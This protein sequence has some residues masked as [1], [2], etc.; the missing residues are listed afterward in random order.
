MITS[1][2]SRTARRPRRDSSSSATAS[3]RSR[4]RRTR[5]AHVLYRNVLFGAVDLLDGSRQGFY[6]YETQGPGDPG[7]RR[8]ARHRRRAGP[9]AGLSWS[10]GGPSG[11]GRATR[12]SS[13]SAGT[14]RRWRTARPSGRR[15]R[16]SGH[17]ADPAGHGIRDREERD[18]FSEPFPHRR[19]LHRQERGRSA[20][21]PFSTRSTGIT[22]SSPSRSRRGRSNDPEMWGLWP[23][24][25]G[26]PK[27]WTFL[28]DYPKKGTEAG[29]HP[30]PNTYLINELAKYQFGIVYAHNFSEVEDLSNQGPCSA[31]GIRVI[32]KGGVA[33]KK[34]HLRLLF[35]LVLM[36]PLMTVSCGSV[37]TPRAG[38]NVIATVSQQTAGSMTFQIGV[39]NTGT[40]TETLLF[41]PV[42][43][44]ISRSKT[45]V[46]GSSGTIL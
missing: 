2:S 33:M 35:V 44:S 19:S 21:G 36:V 29:M 40:K 17:A 13:R 22:S 4:R 46:E 11:S 25:K 23:L 26:C 24:L 27:N 7:R 16:S 31:K 34:V 45:S 42:N 41:A 5:H 28:L 30:R 18:P 32:Q 9:W 38:L 20:S 37:T 1:S 10:T 3:R 6:R 14:S 12:P 8:T 43:S 15:P 39:E